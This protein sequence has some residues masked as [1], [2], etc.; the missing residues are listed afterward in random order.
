MKIITNFTVKQR[1]SR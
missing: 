1:K